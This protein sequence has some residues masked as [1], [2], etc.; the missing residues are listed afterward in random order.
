MPP[1]P[2]IDP[3]VSAGP[4]RPPAPAPTPVP[5]ET[6]VSERQALS[7]ARHDDPD[8][9]ESRFRASTPGHRQAMLT[10][11]VR[12]L[13]DEDPRLRESCAWALH[14]MRSDTGDL[15]E[16][17][18]D[19]LLL[20]TRDA[21]DDV[22][23]WALF[24]LG[25]GGRTPAGRVDVRAAFF[26][27]AAHENPRVRREAIEGLAQLGDL[28]ALRVAIEEFDVDPETVEAAGQV[29]DASLYGP[30]LRMRLRGWSLTPGGARSPELDGLITDAIDR[31]R[32]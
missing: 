30:L 12:H 18:I 25:R 26:E 28:D 1:T 32:P 9:L 24:A 17:A 3:H 22:R 29:G 6:D 11:V 19:G 2:C 4:P 8:A 7:R 23:D 15:D 14:V 21:D 16:T 10:M 31:C 13:D 27:N 5:R 20:L